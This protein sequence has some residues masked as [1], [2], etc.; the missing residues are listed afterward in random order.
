MLSPWEQKT[1]LFLFHQT[2]ELSE[3][4]KCQLGILLKLKKSFTHFSAG[5][6]L[7]IAG[8]ISLGGKRNKEKNVFVFTL[9]TIERVGHLSE[10]HHQLQTR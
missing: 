2:F 6:I 1:L 7:F 8:A 4:R 9:I 3:R 10:V 5:I